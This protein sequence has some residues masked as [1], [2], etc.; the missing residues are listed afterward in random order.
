MKALYNKKRDFVDIK[1]F[2]LYIIPMFLDIEFVMRWTCSCQVRL[3]SIVTP[4]NFVESFSVSGTP[5][6]CMLQS[7]GGVL[8]FLHEICFTYIQRKLVTFKPCLYFK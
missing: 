5:L 3:A 6:I 1:S 7:T 8:I 2:S 4:T